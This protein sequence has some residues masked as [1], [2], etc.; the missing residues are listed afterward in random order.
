VK[1]LVKDMNTALT[2]DKQAN[3]NKKPGFAR[4]KLL[5]AIT[6][7]SRNINYHEELVLNDFCDIAGK[8]LMPLPDN[9]MPNPRI[10]QVILEALSE[11]PVEN[12]HLESS[13]LGV[14]VRSLSVY[15]RETRENKSNVFNIF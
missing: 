8:W 14:L 9:T 15:P 12:V 11:L 1:K 4:F 3:E 10:R 2:L 7:Y 5:D 13:N 6:Q